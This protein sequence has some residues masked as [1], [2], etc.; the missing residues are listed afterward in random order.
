MT[1]SSSSF[2]MKHIASEG[3]YKAASPS[4]S[5]TLLAR[6]VSELDDIDSCLA[7]GGDTDLLIERAG[8][9]SYIGSNGLLARHQH[10]FDVRLW[11]TVQRLPVC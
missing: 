6:L 5:A 10:A 1:S 11:E 9:V 8:V 3:N 7:A 4:A 2:S